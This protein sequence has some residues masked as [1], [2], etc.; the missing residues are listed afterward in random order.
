MSRL[1]EVWELMG[2]IFQAGSVG[3]AVSALEK[4]ESVVED[5]P[6]D[7]QGVGV[8]ALN[9]MENNILLRWGSKR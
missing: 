7:D 5:L 6:E 3:D 9:D 4:L 8:I 1:D 2:V